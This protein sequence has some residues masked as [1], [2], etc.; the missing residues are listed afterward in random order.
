MSTRMSRSRRFLGSA[1]AAIVLLGGGVGIGVALTGGATAATSTTAATHPAGKHPC[2]ARAATR[3]AA[4]KCR[5]G[6]AGLHLV[7][8]GVRG[9]VTV[10]TKTGFRTVA[11]ER[12]T[13]GSVGSGTFTVR[14]P[15]GT[16]WTWHLVKG[17][18]LRSHGSK[19]AASK[20]APGDQVLV[21]GPVVSGAND[22]KLARIRSAS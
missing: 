17:S 5:R 9:Q 16:T 7:Q 18:V 6:L 8:R 21:A 12:G 15:D 19:V 2:A 13:V 4:A 20:L 11:F 14:A 22:V 1:A 10:K 3:K